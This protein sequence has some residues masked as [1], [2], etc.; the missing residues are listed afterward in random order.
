MKYNTVIFDLDG[1]LLNTLEDLADC[2]NHTMRIFGYKERT[3][4]EVRSFVGNGIGMLVRRAVPDYVSDEQY[5]TVFAEYKKYYT[6]NCQVKTKPYDGVRLVVEKLHS[7]GIK[8]AIVTNKNQ[9]AV[10]ELNK[11]YFGDII[12]VAVGDNGIRERKPSTEPV[13]EALRLLGSKAEETIYVGDSEVDVA[14]AQN[15][16]L[17]GVYVTWGF[18]DKEQL[19]AA[20]GENFI[21]KPHELLEYFHQL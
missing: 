5:E 3:I 19:K 18:R 12:N 14:T 21:D 1:T 7:M 8:I 9:M 4:D 10:N 20:G 11:K 2:V 15:S 13:M 17:Y 6:G 16:K